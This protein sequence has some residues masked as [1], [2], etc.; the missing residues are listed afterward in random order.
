MILPKTL[1]RDVIV[2]I[3]NRSLP[4]CL[5]SNPQLLAKFIFQSIQSPSWCKQSWKIL[6]KSASI[7]YLMLCSDV[8]PWNVVM[9][10]IGVM[11]KYFPS[12]FLLKIPKSSDK[13]SLIAA[14][15][16]S[17]LLLARDALAFREPQRE[18]FEYKPYNFIDASEYDLIFPSIITGQ[19]EQFY[20][21]SILRLKSFLQQ[22][23][24][25]KLLK[26]IEAFELIYARKI[27]DCRSAIMALYFA[28]WRN[29][30]IIKAKALEVLGS[31]EFC[32][33]NDEDDNPHYTQMT[34]GPPFDIENMLL[35]FEQRKKKD[36]DIFNQKRSLNMSIQC[37]GLHEPNSFVGFKVAENSPELMQTRNV[38]LSTKKCL[39]PRNKTKRLS[40][41]RTCCPNVEYML[42]VLVYFNEV[43]DLRIFKFDIS[44][45]FLKH[46]ARIRPGLK[47]LKLQECENLSLKEMAYIPSLFPELTSLYLSGIALDKKV[48]IFLKNLRK[49][50][51]LVLEKCPMTLPDDLT[52][53]NQLLS[54]ALSKECQLSEDDLLNLWVACPNVEDLCIVGLN[55]FDPVKYPYPNKILNLSAHTADFDRWIHKDVLII[56]QIFPNLASIIVYGNTFSGKLAAALRKVQQANV[57]KIDF[58]ELDDSFT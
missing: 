11:C 22:F 34:F 33:T 3:G 37:V 12:S 57:I 9:K 56:E 4:D 55:Q 20:W 17:R 52:F 15:N 24:A 45:D 2:A 21:L 14:N 47:H 48:F 38:Y 43:Y 50:H 58:R 23:T 10:T 28:D 31:L 53:F 40:I 42:G 1:S 7:L 35:T 29:F 16:F 26:G 41:D 30:E 51:Q 32:M 36:E 18:T 5:K 27:N 25:W 8:L 44:V 49:L 54:L 13:E 19:Y 46:I 39:I 6:V